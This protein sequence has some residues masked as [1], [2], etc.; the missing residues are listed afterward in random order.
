MQRL[1]FRH[2]EP[3]WARDL[4]SDDTGHS[5]PSV[6]GV[7]TRQDLGPPGVDVG[8]RRVRTSHLRALTKSCRPQP[9]VI[10]E[11]D[12]GALGRL[13]SLQVRGHEALRVRGGLLHL[14]PRCFVVLQERSWDPSTAR[15][16]PIG[17]C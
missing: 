1:V 6:I 17:S 11:P 9:G 4:V 14:E 12:A 2:L 8:A 16:I 3:S 15:P 5:E 13:A 10:V 7:L